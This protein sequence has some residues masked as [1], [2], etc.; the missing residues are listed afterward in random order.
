MLGSNAIVLGHSLALII[1]LTELKLSAGQLVIGKTLQLQLDFIA[2][3][4]QS[5]SISIEL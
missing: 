3:L 2:T 5:V 1:D 4:R